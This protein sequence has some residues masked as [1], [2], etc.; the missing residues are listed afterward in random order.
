M[1]DREPLLD[2]LR[3]VSFA[4]KAHAAELLAPSHGPR[5]ARLAG[6]AV[7]R[8]H[9]DLT[10]HEI[11]TVHN[12]NHAQPWLARATVERHRREDPDFDRRC[13]QLLGDAREVQRQAGYANANLKR[14]LTSKPATG[15]GAATATRI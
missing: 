13:R 2:E 12:V 9:T 4:I 8:E 10:N 14:S 1:T 11:S 3:P 5:I 7:C 15:D 6:I